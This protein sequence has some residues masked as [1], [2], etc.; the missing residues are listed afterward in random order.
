MFKQS[1]ATDQLDEALAKAQG[2]I[3]SATKNANNPHF[4]SKYAN[5]AAVY[6]ACRDSL[7]KHGI[8]HTQWLVHTEDSRLHINTRLAFKGQWLSAIS[9]IPVTKADAQG[10]GSATSYLRRYAL[11]AAI[12]IAQDDDDGNDATKAKP[13][14]EEVKKVEPPKPVE[15]P[16]LVEPVRS[17]NRAPKSITPLQRAAIEKV[18]T[19]KGVDLIMFLDPRD[20]SILSEFSA[21][22]VW[23]ELKAMK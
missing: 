16:K 9:S 21:Y 23:K 11:M 18:A 17:Y 7:S 20:I 3:E 2:E 13:P 4:K 6:D 8:A 19:E 15:P 14:V 22:E 10:Y 5:L 12:G 1:D